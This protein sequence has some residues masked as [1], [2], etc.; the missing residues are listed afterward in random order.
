MQNKKIKLHFKNC[1]LI[2]LIDQNELIIK[3]FYLS[4]ICQFA[5]HFCNF[6]RVNAIRYAQAILSSL[7][8]FRASVPVE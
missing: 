2:D 1:T 7:P 4:N 5:S 8:I 6:I 3:P